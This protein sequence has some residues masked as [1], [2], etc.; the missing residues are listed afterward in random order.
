MAFGMI[1]SELKG[2][3]RRGKFN[4]ASNPNSE[5]LKKLVLGIAK[6]LDAPIF[7]LAAI[8]NVSAPLKMFLMVKEVLPEIPKS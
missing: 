4:L 3:K 8:S 1:L 5:M 2:R 7:P 6:S